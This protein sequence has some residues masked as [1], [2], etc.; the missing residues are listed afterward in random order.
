M[1]I[2]YRAVMQILISDVSGKVLEDEPKYRRKFT[3]SAM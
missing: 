1:Y 2:T 3:L